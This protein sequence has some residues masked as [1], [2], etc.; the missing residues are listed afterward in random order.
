MR[1]GQVGEPGRY[2]VGGT[3]KPGGQLPPRPFSGR[4]QRGP[5]QEMGARTAA[6]GC[7]IRVDAEPGLHHQGAVWR[8]VLTLIIGALVTGLAVARSFPGGSQMRRTSG[9]EGLIGA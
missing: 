6:G 7:V 3:R 4:L 8:A 2:R 5:L 1:L 9:A